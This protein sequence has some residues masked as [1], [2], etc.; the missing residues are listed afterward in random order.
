MVTEKAPKRKKSKRKKPVALD[1]SF[2]ETV[3]R[4]IRVNPK[5]LKK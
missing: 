1:I 2:D 4:L 3:K 5:Q